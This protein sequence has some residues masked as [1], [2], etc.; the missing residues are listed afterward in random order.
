MKFETEVALN[1]QN[2]LYKTYHLCAYYLR[3][4]LVLSR[5]FIETVFI[6]ALKTCGG[7]DIIGRDGIQVL[8][9]IT[10]DVEC[11]YFSFDGQFLGFVGVGQDLEQ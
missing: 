2:Y 6:G 4:G 7:Y 9:K 1:A 10:S 11:P 5:S 8:Y 3:P